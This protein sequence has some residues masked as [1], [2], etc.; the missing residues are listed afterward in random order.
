MIMNLLYEGRHP[1]GSI[2]PYRVLFVKALIMKSTW[3]VVSS[4]VTRAWLPFCEP[5][6]SVFVYTTP[7]SLTSAEGFTFAD[8]LKL[9]VVRLVCLF[10]VALHCVNKNKEL[11][12]SFSNSN[13]SLRLPFAK[14]TSIGTA[15]SGKGF[16]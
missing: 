6:F 4:H 1:R 5:V 9:L 2:W 8:L 7:Y 10:C 12:C 3:K 16:S 11:I 15:S 13:R 14:D